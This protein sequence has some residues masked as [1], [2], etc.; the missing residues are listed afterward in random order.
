MPTGRF[1]D[2]MNNGGVLDKF[3][4][5]LSYTNNKKKFKFSAENTYYNRHNRGQSLYSGLKISKQDAF[6]VKNLEMYASA[7]YEA[8][9]TGSASWQSGGGKAQLGVKWKFRL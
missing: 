4:H 5:E 7:G 3:H 2:A 9:K 8:H 6:G 1:E